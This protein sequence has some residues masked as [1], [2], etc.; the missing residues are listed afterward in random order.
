ME[1]PKILLQKAEEITK[2]LEVKYPELAPF[3]KGCFLNTI[4]TTVTKLD[5]GGYFVITGD[6]P[7]MWLRDSASQL[8]HYIRYANEDE[9]LKEIIRSVILRHAKFVCLDPY[10]NAFNAVANTFCEKDKTDFYHDLIWE[11]KY[12]VDSLCASLYLAHKYYTETLDDSIFTE[13]FHEMLWK[14]VEVFKKEQN[15]AQNSTYFFHRPDVSEIDTLPNGGKGNDVAYTGMTWSGFRPSDD[16]C[17]YNYLVPSNMMAV[18]ALKKG[19]E[20]ANQ[21]Y[22]DTKLESECRSL[23][24]DIDEGIKAHAVYDHPRCG[25]MYAYEVDGLG[26]MLFMD[27]ANSPSLLSAPYIGY[28]DKN[29]EIYKNTRRFI[30]SNENP[31]YFEGAAA[32][33]IGSPH[34]GTNK[35][36]HIA[37]CM[38]ALT[39]DD[40]EEIE[41]CLHMIAETDAGTHLMHESFDKDD[42]TDFTRPWF[43]WANSLLAELLIRLVE[44]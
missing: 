17:K 26:N 43:A 28:A 29:D 5:D 40:K 42:A 35:I 20:M 31:W 44:E 14:I 18:C 7:A 39:S 25:K 1:T 4:E 30:L 10:S 19:A 34:T 41:N 16:R 3:F 21:G 23:A 24:Y 9:D 15:H 32:N 36:W 12:E 13:E 2:K 33:G 27:D 38:Q 6:I 37:L 11:R 22:D 8:T